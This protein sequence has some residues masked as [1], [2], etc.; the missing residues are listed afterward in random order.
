MLM[1]DASSSGATEVLPLY[2]LETTKS[3]GRLSVKLVEFLML[4]VDGS[5]LDT[6]E[7][8]PPYVLE[9]AKAICCMPVELILFQS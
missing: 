4:I 9:M 3:I 5:S 8:L 6:T 7:M 1:V 2:V